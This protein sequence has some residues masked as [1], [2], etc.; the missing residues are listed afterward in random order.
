MTAATPISGPHWGPRSGGQPRQL[1]VLCHGLGADGHDLIDLAPQWATALP[2]AIFVAPDAPEPFAGAPFGRQWFAIGERESGVRTA[3]VAL[4]RF[5]DAELAARGLPADAYALMGFS[6][7]AMTALYTGLRRAVPPRVILSYSGALIDPG[8]LAA[9]MTR[10]P[11][12][13]L[14]VHGQV[15]P[16]V[17][18]VASQEAEQQLRAAG[19]AVETLWCANLPH[20]IDAAGLSAGALALQR[21]F[22]PE[23]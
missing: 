23:T 10:P 20:G 1:V 13:V 9:E 2:D 6:Q 14:L 5:L 21:A 18:I 17:P 22:A 8:S 11:P 19:V 15:D 3:R 4:D 12:P 16:V 7:G